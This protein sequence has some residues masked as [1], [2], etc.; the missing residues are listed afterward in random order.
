MAVQKAEIHRYLAEIGRNGGRKSRRV[1]S[2]D[3]AREMVRV[4]EARRAYQK[5]Y[6]QCFWFMRKDLP[7]TEQDIPAIVRGLRQHGGHEG[8]RIAERL[9]R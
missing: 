7:V 8:M 5:F 4:R 9:C 3:N 1:L 6:A 2:S